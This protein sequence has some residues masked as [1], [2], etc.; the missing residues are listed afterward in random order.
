MKETQTKINVNFRIL[1]FGHASIEAGG[2]E[3]KRGVQEKEVPLYLEPKTTNPQLI[4]ITFAGENY[5]V[6]KTTGGFL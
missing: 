2:F 1:P 3:E 6:P 4:E 5:M